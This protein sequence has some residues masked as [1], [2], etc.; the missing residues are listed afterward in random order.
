MCLSISKFPL[1]FNQFNQ[2]V[3]YK[4]M[5]QKENGELFSCY[6]ETSYPSSGLF[7]SNRPESQLT[8]GEQTDQKVL[9]GVRVF[10]E[11]K[12]A[13]YEK[14]YHERYFLWDHL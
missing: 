11:L 12:D 8:Q 3:C 10:T 9:R 4:V 6:E 14:E 5:Y 1:N 7:T 13:I 2:V